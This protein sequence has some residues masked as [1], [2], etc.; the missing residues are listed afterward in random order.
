MLKALSRLH[1]LVRPNR[2][3]GTLSAEPMWFLAEPD[4]SIASS[5]L[6]APV[7]KAL[8]EL[9]TN[10]VAILPGNVPHDACDALIRDFEEYCRRH[11]ESAQYRDAHALHERLAC[12]HMVSEAARRVVFD[13]NV[14]AIVEAAFR[15]PPVAVGSLFFEKGSTQSVHRDT[16]AFFTNPLN[17]YFGVWTALEA[18]RAGA[19]PLIY[20]RGGHAL[21]PDAALYADRS[22]T[23][24]NYF[25]RIVQA[26]RDA[27]L[28]L[29]EFHPK[30]GDTLIWHPQLAH[31][32]AA[33]TDPSLS[34]RSLVAHFIPEGVPIHGADVFFS[35]EKKVATG[36][37]YRSVKFGRHEAIDQKPRFF[38]NR[39]EGNFDEA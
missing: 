31:G 6:P 13:P 17:R 11:P 30:K 39:Y 18:V 29:V 20:Y 21:A 12:L 5:G 22:V 9:R 15:A 23:A 38:H 25:K 34:R 26:C 35:A 33:I 16:P 3:T 37:N 28:E 24:D 2:L 19:G 10:G 8:S 4:G 27:G 1:R 32:G 36:K 14:T 7:K